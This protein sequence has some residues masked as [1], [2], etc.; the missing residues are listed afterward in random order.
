MLKLWN[1]IQH[2]CLTLISFIF[3]ISATRFGTTIY[4]PICLLKNIVVVFL[5]ISSKF[6]GAYRLSLNSSTKNTDLSDF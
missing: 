3:K 2:I 5:S 4:I 1:F 6:N